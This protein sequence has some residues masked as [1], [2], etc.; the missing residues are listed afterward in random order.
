MTLK[1]V[2]KFN[3]NRNTNEKF[4]NSHIKTFK[5]FNETKSRTYYEFLEDLNDSLLNKNL[6]EDQV[7][8]YIAYFNG[9]G[10]LYDCWESG[11]SPDECI[12]NL[13]IDGEIK[14]YK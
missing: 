3:P 1:E 9:K 2:K 14:W 12:E 4:Q 11:Y 5:L 8:D 13:K 7:F 6:S 10:Y